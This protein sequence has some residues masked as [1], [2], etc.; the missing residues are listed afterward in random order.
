MTGTQYTSVVNRARRGASRKRQVGIVVR[1]LEVGR[2]FARKLGSEVGPIP[3]EL[4]SKQIT[5][6]PSESFSRGPLAPHREVV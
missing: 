1:R 5:T 6:K 4:P 3:Q 2:V